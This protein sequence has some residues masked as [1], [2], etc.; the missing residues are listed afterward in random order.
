M[1]SPNSAFSL[2]ATFT[3]AR[4][5][6]AG[7]RRALQAIGA[8]VRERT[9]PDG[10]SREWT[11]ETGGER[12]LCDAREILESQL[13]RALRHCEDRVLE[14]HRGGTLKSAPR[15]R[16][17]SLDALSIIAAPGA[18]R[19]ARLIDADPTCAKSLTSQG[20]TIAVISDGTGIASLGN[21]GAKPALPIVEGTAALYE[22]LTDLDAVPLVI[23]TQGVETLVD[24]IAALAPNFAA[25]HLEG[26]GA[27]RC[28]AV[29]ALLR[30][31]P[32]IRV[33]NADQHATAVTIL[34][35]LTN[36][37]DLVGKRLED[38]NVVVA[39][40][41]TGGTATT[42]LLL[43]AGARDIIVVE[44]NGVLH[45]DDYSRVA[46]HNAELTQLTNRR[47]RRGQ[48]H[49]VLPG[50]DVFIGLSAPATLKPGLVEL[51]AA[52][53]IVFALATPAP[54]VN[55][56]PLASTAAIV[57]TSLSQYPNQLHNAYAFPG[58]MRGMIDAQVA[59]LDTK[60]AL[61]AAAALARANGHQPR[62]GRLL[63]DLF[64][65]GVHDAIRLAVV[66]ATRA[67]PEPIE[68][69]REGPHR[70]PA[71]LGRV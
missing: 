17:Q 8:Q 10:F 36:A 70:S 28:F 22:S 13:G 41:G 24:T 2:R 26:I 40:G 59:S 37:L 30:A 46:D 51:M 71:E 57:A 45:R 38:A 52:N 43:A 58:L 48:L 32:E 23:D 69:P 44:R 61:A 39:G 54:E 34:A 7:A 67:R 33:L 66:T 65:S 14:A 9:A 50:A 42:Q 49:D 53:P 47:G 4:D 56:K 31:R 25:V 12:A 11:I 21:L 29:D 35:A 5:E 55:P 63:P 1:V 3:P 18:Q 15:L 16:V 20:S 64:A 19:V 68:A 62:P 6:S 27:P 60:P